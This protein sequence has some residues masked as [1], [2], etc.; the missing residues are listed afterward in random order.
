MAKEKYKKLY[1]ELVID[2]GMK[3]E[4]LALYCENWEIAIRAN[5]AITAAPALSVTLGKNGA[6]QPIAE[7]KILQASIDQMRRLYV[8][9]SPSIKLK[10]AGAKLEL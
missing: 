9:L 2:S 6:S 3:Q 1:P 5:A 8:L 4:L 7:F 10:D